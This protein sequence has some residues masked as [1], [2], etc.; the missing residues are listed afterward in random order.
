MQ[1]GSA[2]GPGRFDNAD[3]AAAQGLEPL[4]WAVVPEL[5]RLLQMPSLPGSNVVLL[6]G[7]KPRS[8]QADVPVTALWLKFGPAAVVELIA[9]ID[10]LQIW[11]LAAAD[12]S[13]ASPVDILPPSTCR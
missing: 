4:V 12:D 9:G 13:A 2:P 8:Q 6:F 5:E 7:A 10:D 11:L 1:L 3:A